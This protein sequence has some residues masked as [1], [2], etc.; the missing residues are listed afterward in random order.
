MVDRL[1]W[2]SSPAWSWYNTFTPLFEPLPHPDPTP[3]LPALRKLLDALTSPEVGWET[4]QIHLFGWGQGGTIALEL[5][6]D[7]GK[8][9][10]RLGSVISVCAGLFSHPSTKMDLETP[11]LYFTRSDVR[12]WSGEK[13]VNSLKRAFKEVEVVRGDVGRGEDMPR[14]RG[15]WEGIMRFWARLLGRADK[16]WK[17]EGEV[18]EV[19]R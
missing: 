9:K 14:G 13:V 1:P 17:G 2:M 5:A 4:D 3:S 8:T 19:V 15:E 11:V 7:L 12:F 10:R 16:G 18:Y 6:C